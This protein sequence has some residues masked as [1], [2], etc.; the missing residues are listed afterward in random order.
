MSAGSMQGSFHKTY[1]TGGAPRPEVRC[2]PD[3]LLLTSK[4]ARV[5]G[6]ALV[7][8]ALLSVGWSAYL[9]VGGMRTDTISVFA[10]VVAGVSFFASWFFWSKLRLLHYRRFTFL[11]RS[12]TR[13][14]RW[15]LARDEAGGIHLVQIMVS[16]PYCH[17]TMVM[18][19]VTRSL[20]Y[21]IC[22]RNPGLHR[23]LFEPSQL[24]F[25]GSKEVV[26]SAVAKAR[27]L[28]R[29]GR[30]EEAM[31]VIDEALRSADRAPGAAGALRELV[32]RGLVIKGTALLQLG[33]PEEAMAVIDEVVHHAGNAPAP[34]SWT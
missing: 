28:L 14:P 27:A 12:R 31:A 30:P 2:T 23:A 13:T 26:R 7:A 17:G 11:Y 16:C 20:T 5:A 15:P 29:W 22:R 32:V 8:V 33:R 34:H 4:Q 25:G 18:R 6:F 9:D 21:L 3:R 1:H 10:H 24:T 19:P